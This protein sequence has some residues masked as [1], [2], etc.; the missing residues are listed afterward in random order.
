MRIKA[1]LRDTDILQMEPGSKGRVLAA[2]KK[3]LDR[4]VNLPS[5]LKVMGLSY[6]DRCAMLDA[7]KDSTIHVWLLMDAQQHLIYLSEKNESE[8]GGY[9]WQ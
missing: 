9:Q 6:D 3:N 7:I 8:F 4:V 2:A 1:V 5:L